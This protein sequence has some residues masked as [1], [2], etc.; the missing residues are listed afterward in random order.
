MPGHSQIDTVFAAY[1]EPVRTRLLALRDLILATA[2]ATPGVGEIE[3]TLRWGQPSY[4]TPVSRSGSTIRIDAVK[5]AGDRYALY[6][7][8]QTDLL[9]RFRDLYGE[10][11]TYEGKRALVFDAAAPLDEDVVSHCISLA[12]THHSRKSAMR[13]RA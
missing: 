3:E 2:R 1:R 4:L 5:G 8:C 9:A 7:H 13:L 11:L 6:V 10:A 12:L